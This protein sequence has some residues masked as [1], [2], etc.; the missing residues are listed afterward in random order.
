VVSRIAALGC[1]DDLAFVSRGSHRYGN[2]PEQLGTIISALGGAPR[3]DDQEVLLREL[4]SRAATRAVHYRRSNMKETS[5]S[6]GAYMTQRGRCGTTS[7]RLTLEI[8]NADLKTGA[9]VW[10]HYYNA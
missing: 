1:G 6:R 10:S 3:G 5:R 7:T 4:R 2:G 8:G 9:T